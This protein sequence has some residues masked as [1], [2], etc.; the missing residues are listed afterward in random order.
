MKNT[1]KDESQNHNKKG[2]PKKIEKNANR[3]NMQKKKMVDWTTKKRSLLLAEENRRM[4]DCTFNTKVY[5]NNMCLFN[6]VYFAFVFISFLVIP[7]PLGILY[8]K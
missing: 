3:K 7:I 6:K 2:E 5:S 8:I 1:K 4:H